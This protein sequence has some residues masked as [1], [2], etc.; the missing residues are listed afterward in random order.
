MF[1]C[2]NLN[3][4][5]FLSSL[6]LVIESEN[7]LESFCME[8]IKNLTLNNSRKFT[9]SEASVRRRVSV[10]NLKIIPFLPTLAVS[11]DLLMTNSFSSDSSVIAIIIPF[12]KFVRNCVSCVSTSPLDHKLLRR[13]LCWGRQGRRSHPPRASGPRHRCISSPG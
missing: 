4:L 6:T 5:V 11:E 2:P 7:L 12:N 3:T 10:D 8:L 9:S 1:C 13:G